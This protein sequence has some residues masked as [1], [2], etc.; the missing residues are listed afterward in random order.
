MYRAHRIFNA[1]KDFL[2]PAVKVPNVGCGSGIVGSIIQKQ[3]GCPVVGKDI[4]CYVETDISFQQMPAEDKLLFPD[5][6]FVIAML[7]DI[8]CTNGTARPG[9][10]PRK[11]ALVL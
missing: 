7:K 4:L 10:P 6:S 9:R 2:M 8:P 11:D 1:Y 3:F 5:G